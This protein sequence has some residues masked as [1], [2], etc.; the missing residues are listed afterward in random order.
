MST[1]SRAT[2]RKNRLFTTF[3]DGDLQWIESVAAA[4]ALSASAVVRRCIHRERLRA[5]ADSGHR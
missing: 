1:P 2:K 3:G 4:E 5:Q